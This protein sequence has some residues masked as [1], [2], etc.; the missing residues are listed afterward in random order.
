MPRIAEFYGIVIAMFYLD[1]NPPHFHAIYGEYRALVGVD[2]VRMLE[3]ELPRRAQ[4]L[5]FE[6]TAMHQA[7]LAD[8][9]N[10]ARKHE[11]LESIDPLD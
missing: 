1:H 6:W 5:V 7:E 11:P 3:G 4:S 2:P 8:N 10:R 9:W